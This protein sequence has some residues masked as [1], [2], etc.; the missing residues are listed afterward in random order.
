MADISGQL[1]KDSY[2]NV[3]QVDP[4]T[5]EFLRIGGERVQN[6]VF[7]CGM[8]ISQGFVYSQGAQ[9][10]YV[11]QSD[12][13]G[14]AFWAIPPGGI[15]PAGSSGSSGESGTS[16]SAGA[17]GTSGSSGSRGTSGSSGAIGT[18]GSSGSRGTSG[19]SG[20]NGTSGSS[21][22]GTISG[23]VSYIPRFQDANTLV[24]SGTP[25]Y[26]D[27]DNGSVGMGLTSPN[28]SA[29]LHLAPLVKGIY[30]TLLLPV[31]D[32]PEARVLTPAE[33]MLAY[34]TA[35]QTMLIYT[36]TGWKSVTLNP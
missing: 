12:N 34:S 17:T 30:K 28:A 22:T 1:I 14:N 32:S 20:A 13:Y 8:T 25:I 6:P 26:E 10:G 15:G 31:I 16:G 5:G 11:L 21:G 27:A 18:S 3:I 29:V 36:S 35:D 24:N 2:N 23:A 19:S 7:L 9:N 4:L 33:G